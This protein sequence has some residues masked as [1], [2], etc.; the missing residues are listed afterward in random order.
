MNAKNLIV[1]SLAA[2][3][4][5]FLFGWVF[6]GILFPDIYPPSET[7]NIIFVYLGCLTFCVLLSYIFL[8]WAGISTPLTGAKAGGIVG[9][10]YGAGMNFFM[11]SNMSPNY[12]NIISDIIINAVMGAIAGVTIAFVYSKI[13]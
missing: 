9:L 2:S 1:T 4:I 8:S 6:Y 7:Q 5:Y 10:L 11:Y 12:T 3:V 13:K